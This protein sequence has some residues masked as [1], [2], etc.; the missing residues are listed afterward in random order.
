LINES[1][2]DL[3]N[4][5]NEF[6]DTVEELKTPPAALDHLKKNKDLYY[7]VRAK[8]GELDARRDPIKMKF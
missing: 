3:N 4:L 6:T 8:M 7:Q 5:L 1:K 2:D